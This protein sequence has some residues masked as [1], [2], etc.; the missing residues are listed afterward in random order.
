MQH[1]AALAQGGEVRGLVIRRVVVAVR[2]RQDD[3]GRAGALQQAVGW[4]QAAD[5]LAGP[6]TPPM[7]LFV[8]PAPVPKVQDHAPVWPAAG[9]APTFGTAEADRGRQLAPVDRI[10]PAVVPADRH[11]ENLGSAAILLP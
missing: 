7:G 5:P 4:L 2:R 3:A 9:L 6:V 11:G 10:E 1:V 8:P